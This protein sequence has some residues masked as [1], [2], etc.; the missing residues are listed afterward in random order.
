MSGV[1]LSVDKTSQFFGV[2]SRTVQRWMTNGCP[3]SKDP[4]GRWV[5]NSAAVSEWLRQRERESAL[6][7]VS[8]IDEDEARRRK[9]SAEA[10]LAEFE[11]AT[12]QGSAVSIEHF[13]KVMSLMVASARAKLLNLGAKLAPLLIGCTSV[14]EGKDA[15]DGGIR[16]VLAELSVSDDATIR[17]DDSGP[18]Q[19]EPSSAES[20]PPVGAAT[21]S[22]RKRVGRRGAKAKP[23]KQR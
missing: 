15:I 1:D 9:I 16:E 6:G 14:T 22:D 20:I 18:V 19:P 3:G 8:S 13:E 5:I 23:R 4:K 12:K 2:D 10:A 11:L 7:E 17:N 21:G